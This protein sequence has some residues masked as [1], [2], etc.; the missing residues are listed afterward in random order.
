[1]KKILFVV[2]VLALMCCFS[3]G[4]M[5]DAA[6]YD[7]GT[8]RDCDYSV[9]V[10]TVDGGVNLREAP[11]TESAILCL[12]PDFVQLRITMESTNGNGWGYTNYN[13]YHGWVA[14]S[15][16]S[17]YYPVSETSYDVS[18]TATDG[19]NLREGPYTSYGKLTN[20]PHA[21]V[22]HVE[23]TY[24]GWG[25]VSY[26]G[27]YGWIALSQVGDA[28]AEKEDHEPMPIDEDSVDV[29]PVEEEATV[30]SLEKEDNGGIPLMAILIGM[31]ILVVVIAAVLIIII[32]I[33][34]K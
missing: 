4:V 14:L 18:V 17:E 21:T 29:E 16:V 13:G 23:A 20:I 34:K 26:G 30:T 31:I 12:I 1:M 6:I 28:V 32:V 19:V 8:T 15:Q 3:C 2:L 27:Y 25:A 7:Y 5:A 10:A 9:Y 33:K 22:L 24:N 11:T